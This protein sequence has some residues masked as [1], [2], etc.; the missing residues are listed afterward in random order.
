MWSFRQRNG[1]CE[2]RSWCQMCVGQSPPSLHPLGNG[3]HQAAAK[4]LWRLSSQARYVPRFSF[5]KACR[6][7][8]FPKFC[9]ILVVCHYQTKCKMM[10]LCFHTCSGRPSSDQVPAV[11]WMCFHL[12]L[13]LKL[14]AHW[15]CFL[16]YCLYL[17]PHPKQTSSVRN[18]AWTIAL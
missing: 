5:R 2:N 17:L 7:L 8:F 3:I 9:P 6:V 11:M 18:Q 10:G 4:G 12:S 13:L 16:P 1:L 14:L 15:I